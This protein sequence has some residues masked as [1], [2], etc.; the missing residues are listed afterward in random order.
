VWLTRVF[1]TRLQRL[2]PTPNARYNGLYDGLRTMIRTEGVGSL[3]SGIRV[4]AGG[5]GPAHALYF[6]TYE[7]CKVLFGVKVGEDEDHYP[8]ETGSVSSFYIKPLTPRSGSRC[9]R[10]PCS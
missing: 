1:Q 9:V 8:A 2:N 10:H 4:V 3:F 5:A 6:A 7:E